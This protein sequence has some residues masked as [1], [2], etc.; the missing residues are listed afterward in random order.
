[1][2][3]LLFSQPRIYLSTVFFSARVFLPPKPSIY[4][5]DAGSSLSVG[6]LGCSI[7]IPAALTTS[8][9]TDLDE[10]MPSPNPSPL[11]LAEINAESQDHLAQEFIDRLDMVYHSASL[12]PYAKITF[13][14]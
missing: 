5:M 12:P 14:R 13:R 9:A 6:G 10:F 8:D 4:N 3:G 7:E 1:M 11:T 2:N